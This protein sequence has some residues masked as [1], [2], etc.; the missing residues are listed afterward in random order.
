MDRRFRRPATIALV[1]GF[2][3]LYFILIL[4]ALHVVGTDDGLYYREQTDAGILPETGI[5]DEDLRMLDARLAEYLKGGSTALN[6]GAQPENPIA[7]VAVNGVAQP[8]FNEKEM[9]HLDDCFDLFELLR[10]VRARLVPWAILL[11]VSGAYLLQDRRRIRLCAWLSPL[12]LLIPLGAF[13]AWAAA[14]FDAAFTFFHKMLFANDLWLLDPRTDLLIR[15]CPASMFMH[16][17]VRIGVLSLAAMLAVSAAATLLT[18]IWPKGKEDD[19]WN[20]RA[21]RRGSA[22]K[23]ITFGR[24]GMR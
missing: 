4:T 16:M 20:N 15:I 12:I 10:W 6:E 1:L 7:S 14:D 18:F 22:Q 17:G 19:T 9:S 13:A 23:Q 24:T 11:I 5:S 2:A 3:V 21:M 8:A